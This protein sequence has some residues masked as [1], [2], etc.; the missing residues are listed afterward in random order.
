MRYDE[1][2][3]IRQKSSDAKSNFAITSGFVSHTPPGPRIEVQRGPRQ[4]RQVERCWSARPAQGFKD[5]GDRWPQV[6]GAGPGTL[7]ANPLSRGARLSPITRLA[8]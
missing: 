8:F 2:K 4:G 7:V 5:C 3:N 1:F 6:S